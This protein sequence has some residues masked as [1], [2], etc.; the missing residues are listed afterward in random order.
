V[1]GEAAELSDGR[2]EVIAAFSHALPVGYDYLLHRVG[3]R[4]TAEDLTSET[5]LSAYSSMQRDGAGSL[6][7]AWLIGIARHKLVD[8][9]RRAERDE[10][11]LE[12]MA[13]DWS[14]T[15]W[16]V[17][18]EPGRA[19]DVLAELNPWQRAALV[20]RYVDGLPVAE[21]GE[22]LGRTV[23]ATEVLLVRAKQAFRTRYESGGDPDA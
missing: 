13:G 2:D 23:G 6:S 19:A 9:W 16:D 3:V 7:I 12:V 11:R 8:H 20:L 21:V 4:Q 17:V 5:F 15:T 14:E 10:R 18:I 1:R 22:L